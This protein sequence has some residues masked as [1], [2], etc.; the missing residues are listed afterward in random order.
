MKFANVNINTAPMIEYLKAHYVA[1]I[2]ISTTVVVASIA[3][4]VTVHL[5]SKN[6]VISPTVPV[7]TI[8]E[9]K[10]A[11]SS[12]LEKKLPIEVIAREEASSEP[13]KEIE[14]E[15]GDNPPPLPPRTPIQTTPDKTEME[16]ERENPP[17][18]PP[19]PPKE[20]SE[21]RTELERKQK[22]L[23]D[24]N[25]E[26]ATKEQ[27]LRQLDISSTEITK[28]IEALKEQE[29]ELKGK[30]KDQKT[31][32]FKGKTTEEIFALRKQK[33]DVQGNIDKIAREIA[34]LGAESKSKIAD[35]ARAE[36][37]LKTLDAT[38]NEC[39]NAIKK[40]EQEIETLEQDYEKQCKSFWKSIETERK[41]KKQQE[42]AAKLRGS[43]RSQIRKGYTL[44]KWL[45][46]PTKTQTK[47]QTETQTET[48]PESSKKKDSLPTVWRMLEKQDDAENSDSDSDSD[49][50]WDDD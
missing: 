12:E 36:S 45:P 39:G 42:S 41:L 9:E 34:N 31:S 20:L 23:N 33:S 50:D 21:K 14:E 30:L 13:K 4:P 1:A 18:K 2:A 37:E 19:R 3:I 16:P 22:E 46:P 8:E 48:P 38:I 49:S 32:S 29:T 35:I 6:T 7:Q 24:L 47:T 40:L 17:P 5:C 15:E 11:S 44:K 28:S 26:K 10:N 43:L 25:A 27:Q